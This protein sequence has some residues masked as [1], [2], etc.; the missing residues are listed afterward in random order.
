[1]HDTLSKLEF[2]VVQDIFLTKTA[3]FADVV[4]PAAP[5]LEKDGTFTNTER[6][7]QRLY[8]ALEPLGE[9]KPD[10]WI[11]QQIAKYMGVNWNYKHPSEI[12]DEIANLCPTFAGV[13]YVRLEGWNSLIWPVQKDGTDEPLLYTKRFNFPDG[14]ARFSLTEYVPPIEFTQEFDLTLNNGRLLEHFHEGN[15]TNKSKGIQYKLPEV[16]VEVSPKLAQ[17]RKVEDGTLVRLVSPYGAIKLRAVVTD[18]VQGNELYV[19]MHSVSH[20]N[21]IN[22][23]TG[24][25]GD[26]RTETPAYKQI[27]VKMEVIEKKGNR[28]LPLYNPRYAK[29]NPQLGVQV[30]RK[31]ARKDYEQIAD[32]NVPGGK[33][34]GKTN[35]EN[36]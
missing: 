26:V 19:P 30:E 9:S 4:L 5:S 1:V 16:F 3:Q 17:E 32:L 14:K 2:F 11:I 8:Q 34:N 12:M 27:K 24:S 28:P 18:R 20:E 7:I 33:N 10:W 6:R 22:L 15:L 13:S 31:W 25:V 36:R 21:A 35:Y 29:R 23:L